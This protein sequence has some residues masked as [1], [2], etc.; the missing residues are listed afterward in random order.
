V[1]ETIR[2]NINE[3]PLY[4]GQIKSIGPRYCP[5]IEDKVVKFPD[6]TRHQLFLEPEGYDTYEVYLNGFSTS[7]PSNLQQEL[8]HKILGFEEAKIIRPGYAIEYDFVDPR[9][10]TPYLQTTCIKGL[11]F[12]GQI[13]GTT[14]Y[15][16]AGCQGLL[17]GINASLSVQG[18][19]GFRLRREESY[20]G[21]LVDD[22]ITQGVDEP[23]RMFTSR[24]ENRLTLRYDTSDSRLS[25]YGRQ[26]GLIGDNEW[27]KFSE[28]REHLAQLRSILVRTRFKRS[29]SSYR[30]F[31]CLLGR[32]LG[33][34]ISLVNLSQFSGISPSMIF[35]YLPT[36]LRSATKLPDLE[37][38]LAD[39]LY[40]GY[41]RSHSQSINYLNN[42]ED[43]LIPIGFNYK[44]IS[45]LSHEMI[46]RL[47]RIQPA[48]FGQARRISG[49]TASA[50]STL[51]FFLKSQRWQN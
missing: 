25:P 42:N 51:L 14:G 11:F 3:S 48:N 29:D 40:H 9:E 27:E 20:I 33:D 37:T 16:E 35:N 17:A 32:D 31:A 10:L 26:L 34:S 8:V 21:V 28:R 13:N 45:G 30:D 12:A 1:H 38:T 24:S 22:L 41:I 43:L 36:N 7:L 49:M 15:E 4:S 19:Q 50:L 5:S 2:A 6:K 23:Y 44:Q 18:R 47:E 46:E 39:L